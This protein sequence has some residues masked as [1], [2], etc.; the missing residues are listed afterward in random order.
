[1]LELLSEKV[2]TA[3]TVIANDLRAGCRRR[4]ITERRHDRLSQRGLTRC[5]PRGPAG[6]KLS[7]CLLCAWLAET[8]RLVGPVAGLSPAMR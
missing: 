1:M 4:S 8:S 2:V 5:A 6:P 7:Y 3:T